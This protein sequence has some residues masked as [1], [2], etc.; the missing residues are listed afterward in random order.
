[1]NLIYKDDP[2]GRKKSPNL[3]ENQQ[4]KTNK[5]TNKKSNKK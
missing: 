1:M 4:A 5:Q 3:K 2:N